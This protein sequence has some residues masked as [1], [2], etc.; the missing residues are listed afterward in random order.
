MMEVAVVVVEIVVSS[1]CLLHI[2]WKNIA[3]KYTA[4]IILVPDA[5]KLQPILVSIFNSKS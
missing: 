1:G 5:M 3:H 2:H 4:V